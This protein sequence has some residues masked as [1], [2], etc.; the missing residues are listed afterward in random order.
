MATIRNLLEKLSKLS[1]NKIVA[2]DHI[3]DPKKSH[4]KYQESSDKH[5][6]FFE[7]E[8]QK[9]YYQNFISQL[10]EGVH[11]AKPYDKGE[12]GPLGVRVK[13]KSGR[14]DA[15][16]E[17]KDGDASYISDY[18]GGAIEV[19]SLEAMKHIIKKIKDSKHKII[20]VDNMLSGRDNDEGYRAVHLQV[21]LD[22]GFS[23]ELQLLPEGI[24]RIKEKLHPVYEKYRTPEAE[25]RSK[26]DIEFKTKMDNTHK[27]L[28][29]S[30]AKAFEEFRL[31]K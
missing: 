3:V 10:S 16:I 29:Q 1:E 25:E 17:E 5:T 4:I 26:H 2:S 15:K 6:N 14:V 8:K 9:N 13:R 24:A 12:G 31:Y 21:Q 22:N 19:K 30:Y 7:A 28:M 11:G 27:K 23:A 20:E 18:L